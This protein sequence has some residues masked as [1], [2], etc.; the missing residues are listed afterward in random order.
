M[1]NINIMRNKDTRDTIYSDLLIMLIILNFGGGL[2][3]LLDLSL[4]L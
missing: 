4:L 3:Y 1:N 2:L